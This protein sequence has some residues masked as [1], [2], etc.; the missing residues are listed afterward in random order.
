[1]RPHGRPGKRGHPSLAERAVT[2]EP[3]PSIR[4]GRRGTSPGWAATHA[5]P[6]RESIMA[7]RLKG[8]SPFITPKY[9]DLGP[10]P[11]SVLFYDLETTGIDWPRDRVVQYGARL[12]TRDASGSWQASNTTIYCRPLSDQPPAPDAVAIHGI[13][14]EFAKQHGIPEPQLAA[15]IRSDMAKSRTVTIGYNSARF[16]RH[17]VRALFY[18]NFEPMYS[19]E[20]ANGCR[21]FDAFG[22]VRLF[23]ALLPGALNTATRDDGF[24]S[25]SLESLATENGID[26]DAHDAL[27]D[28]QATAA[29]C[30]ILREASPE[31]WRAACSRSDRASVE[32]D[33]GGPGNRRLLLHVAGACPASDPYGAP[34]A[35]VAIDPNNA[36]RR[37]L[38]DLRH[39]PR[40]LAGLD[41]DAIAAGLAYGSPDPLPVRKAATN[42]SPQIFPL[43]ATQAAALFG[44]RTA[45]AVADN[46]MRL[47]PITTKLEELL[48]RA[49]DLPGPASPD[50][51]VEERMYDAFF[52]DDDLATIRAARDRSPSDLARLLDEASFNDDRAR[53]LVFRYVARHHNDLLTQDE[54][55]EWQTRLEHVRRDLAA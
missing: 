12:F 27:G 42:A 14:P 50:R 45:M 1:M 26:H 28:V 22:A 37:L 19:H 15:R 9:T 51:D 34:V 3:L 29:I 39:D 52:N 24:T 13:T 30:R 20:Y 38:W 41:T 47:E 44:G 32:A 4:R 7:E 23:E 8:Q 10:S 33:M 55:D 17:F 11:R 2:V 21:A 53:E 31:L 54:I 18:R 5:I 49:I 48:R 25:L 6:V 40:Q 46:L 43:D 36:R 35:V 16:D